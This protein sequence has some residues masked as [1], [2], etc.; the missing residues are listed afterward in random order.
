M[1]TYSYNE[2]VG[3]FQAPGQ[4]GGPCGVSAATAGGVSRSVGGTFPSEEDPTRCLFTAAHTA[5]VH[6][7]GSFT[8]YFSIQIF[9]PCMRLER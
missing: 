1:F 5:A 4:L 3:L 7:G 2:W 9:P 8:F 6:A